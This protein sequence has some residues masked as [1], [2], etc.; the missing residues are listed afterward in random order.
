[1]IRIGPGSIPAAYISMVGRDERY[2][3]GGYGGDLLADCLKRIARIADQIGIAVVLLDVLE[4]GN[5]EKTR[6]R[7]ELYA[8][9]GFQSL[10]SMPMRMFLPVATIKGLLD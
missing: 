7:V 3:S 2:R 9:Y 1:M 6:R 5:E 4:C 8:G 10:P